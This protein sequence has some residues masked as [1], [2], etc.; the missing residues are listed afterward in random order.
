MFKEYD[1]AHLVHSALVV[2]LDLSDHLLS[3][4]S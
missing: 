2:V 3:R 4:V 1:N